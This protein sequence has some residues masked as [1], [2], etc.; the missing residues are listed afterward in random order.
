MALLQWKTKRFC[1]SIKNET[2][3]CNLKEDRYTMV[4]FVV[5]IILVVAV[6]FSMAT[7]RA[8]NKYNDSLKKQKEKSLER[9]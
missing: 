7:V 3:V 1:Y 5:A 4:M 6:Y 2:G 9:E 8:S